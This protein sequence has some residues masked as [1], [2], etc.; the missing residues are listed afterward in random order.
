MRYYASIVKLTVSRTVG[1]ACGLALIGSLGGCA[2]AET[3]PAVAGVSFSASKTR[4]AIDSPIE[5]TYRF[6]VTESIPDDYRVFVHVTDQNGTILWND[7]HDPPEPTSTWLP[8]ETLEYSRTRFVPLFPYIGQ[9]N[10]LMG[11]HRGNARLP[12]TTPDGG[13]E[14]DNGRAYLVGSL[15]L[16]PT[17][18]NIF[19]IYKSGWHPAEFSPDDPTLEWQWTDQSA[20]L[21]L[22][23]P[24]QDVMLYLEFDARPDAFGET[25]QAVTVFAGSEAVETF[26]AAE[27]VPTLRRIPISAA[28]LGNDDMAEVRIAVDRTFLPA[29]LGLE[30]QDSRE[31]GIRVYHVFVEPR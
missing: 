21:G 2:Q 5:L 10:V 18:E 29:D 28:A 8:G 7:D 17:S 25:P 16:L 26:V 19:L 12:L 13:G 6:A 22:R 3:E 11:L 23:N 24:R 9:A 31:L 30:G 27:A 20:V 15:E 14:F 1:T 4:V